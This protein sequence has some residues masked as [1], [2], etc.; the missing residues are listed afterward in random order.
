M[1]IPTW[2]LALTAG[3]IVVLAA[4]GVGLVAASTTP[5]PP[6]A[7]PAV[8]APSGAPVGPAAGGA[9]RQRLR[10]RLARSLVRPFARHLVHATIT[11]TDKDGNLVT[12]QLDHGTIAAIGGG[13][14]TISE[15]GGSSVTVSTDTNTVVFLGAG[16]GKGSLSDLK[17]GDEIA[18]RSRIDGTTTLAKRILRV[19]AATTSS[20]T[21]G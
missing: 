7:A 1:R 5:P 3:A 11:V 6:P 10:D 19:P 14:L 15:A 4:V 8:A 16:A 18:V 21:S 13:S 17:V 9:L 12:L 20:S 2:R